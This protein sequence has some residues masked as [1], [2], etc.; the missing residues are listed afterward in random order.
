MFNQPAAIQGS[1]P[2]MSNRVI[3]WIKTRATELTRCERSLLSAQPL[4]LT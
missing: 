4:L 3:A 2:S 1:L